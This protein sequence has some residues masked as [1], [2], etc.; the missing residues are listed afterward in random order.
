MTLIL[1]LQAFVTP[2]SVDAN[3]QDI[4]AADDENDDFIDTQAH[5]RTLYE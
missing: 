5:R 1:F 2:Q 4:Q 3:G